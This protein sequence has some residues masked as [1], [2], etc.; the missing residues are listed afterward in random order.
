MPQQ[1]SLLPEN[2]IL[3]ALNDQIISINLERKQ[4]KRLVLKVTPEGVCVSAPLNASNEIIRQ[5]IESNKDWLSRKYKDLMPLLRPKNEWTHGG[6][7]L[8]LGE[9]VSIECSEGVFSPVLNGKVLK[10]PSTNDSLKVRDYCVSW[11]YLMALDILNKR[12]QFYVSKTQNSFMQIKL[13]KSTATWGRCSSKKE[14]QLNWRLIHLPIKLIDYVIV[15]E[16]A[17]LKHLDHSR[18]FWTEVQRT[19]PNYEELDKE[20]KRYSIN[21]LK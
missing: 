13:S 11:L 21:S 6:K 7:F 15:H 20:M 19:L 10:I 9:Y 18:K 4:R 2:Q 12:T 3:F 8:Y 16:L 17:H 5:F 14:I 1:L